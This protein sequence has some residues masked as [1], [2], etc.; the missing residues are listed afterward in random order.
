MCS[1]K[2]EAIEKGKFLVYLLGK[3]WEYRVFKTSQQCNGKPIWYYCADLAGGR[4]HVCPNSYGYYCMLDLTY[5]SAIDDRWEHAMDRNFRD[6]REAVLHVFL[7]MKA[8]LKKEARKVDQ[9]EGLLM[10]S[11]VFSSLRPK[12]K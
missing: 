3:G 2:K 8:A 4:I 12:H 6:P 11:R 9:I 5:P 7:C 1:S 10:K